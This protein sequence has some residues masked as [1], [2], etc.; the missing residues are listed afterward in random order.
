[1]DFNLVSIN[2]DVFMDTAHMRLLFVLTMLPSM[3]VIPV[4]RDYITVK[5]ILSLAYCG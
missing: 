5:L 2:Y 3:P 4:I 1:M